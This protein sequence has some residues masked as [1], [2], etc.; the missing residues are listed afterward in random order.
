MCLKNINNIMEASALSDSNIKDLN[1]M[2][3]WCF[4]NSTD[5]TDI[6]CE[7]TYLKETNESDRVSFNAQFTFNWQDSDQ[8]IVIGNNTGD[9]FNS[10]IEIKLINSI[11]LMSAVNAALTKDK[12]TEEDFR[13]TIKQFNKE[14][15]SILEY[16]RSLESWLKTDLIN[17]E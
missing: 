8:Y 5:Y 15:E 6:E 16:I 14:F 10:K 3:W 1:S 7:V 2:G 11:D 4:N 17:I 13:Q 12:G 9:G